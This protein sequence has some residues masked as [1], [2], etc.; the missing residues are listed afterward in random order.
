[1][2]RIDLY[3]TEDQN[4]WLIEK[5]REH[6]LSGKSE[7]LRRI[8]DKE[9]QWSRIRKERCMNESPKFDKEKYIEHFKDNYKDIGKKEE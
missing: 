3:V 8:L 4:E 1:V 7:L 9:R 2:K 6:G 5:S